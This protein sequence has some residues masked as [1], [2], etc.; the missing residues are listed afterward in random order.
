MSTY[1]RIYLNVPE[2]LL[3]YLSPVT[4]FNEFYSLKEHEAVFLK[5]QK[6]IFSVVA[7]CIWFAFCFR[8]NTFTSKISNL[9]LTSGAEGAKGRD[10]LIYYHKV[11]NE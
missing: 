9:L 4:Y 8:L 1:A 2:L 7:G 3:F 6:L 5:R 10:I 11:A